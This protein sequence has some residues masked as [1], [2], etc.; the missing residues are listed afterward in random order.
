[1]LLLPIAILGMENASDR[2]FMAQLYMDNRKFMYKVSMKI[3]RDEREVEDAINDACEALIKKIDFLQTLD[4]CSLRAYVVSTIRNVSLNHA[5]RKKKQSEHAYMAGDEAFLGIAA[6]GE[7]V[8][9]GVIGAQRI[10][11]LKQMLASLPERERDVLTMKYLNELKDAEIA[12]AL[13]IKPGSVR[14]YLT[15]ARRHAQAVM[16]EMLK[17]EGWREL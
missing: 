1:M 4:S 8:D 16:K 15:T 2:V 3:L 17:G 12:Q 5:R 9:A 14:A 7:D 6:P 11:A 10:G 13:G